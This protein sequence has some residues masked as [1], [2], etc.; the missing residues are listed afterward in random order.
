MFREKITELQA[1]KLIIIVDESKVVDKLGRTGV[2][3]DVIPFAH[4]ITGRKLELV[5]CKAVL[6]K[7]NE[8]M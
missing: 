2:S 6:R 4:N 3:V 7:K 8:K 1:K 5:G